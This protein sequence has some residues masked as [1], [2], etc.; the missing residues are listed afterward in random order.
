MHKI[1]VIEDDADIRAAM[2][3]TLGLA[4]YDVSNLN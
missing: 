3:H 2:V 1:L 4:G